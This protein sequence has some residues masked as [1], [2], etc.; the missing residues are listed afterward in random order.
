LTTSPPAAR[1][2]QGGKLFERR[3]EDEPL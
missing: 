1:S 3:Q 2:Y